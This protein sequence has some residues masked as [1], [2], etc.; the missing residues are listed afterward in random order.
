MLNM[1][2]SICNITCKTDRHTHTHSHSVREHIPRQYVHVHLRILYYMHHVWENTMWCQ[3]KKYAE[4]WTAVSGLVGSHQQ[5]IP[6][7]LSLASRVYKGCHERSTCG[8]E[9]MRFITTRHC[10]VHLRTYI[11]HASCL[12]NAHTSCIQRKR[13]N[14]FSLS[15][16][17]NTL[18]EGY[19]C[20][21]ALHLV[22][23][24]RG[25]WPWYYGVCLSVIST[26]HFGEP[27]RE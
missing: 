21:L 9:L 5:S 10:Y 26:T 23:W 20:A 27:A 3:E 16:E 6:Q 22:F 25:Q 14:F 11:L 1:V 12:R 18:Q 13:E 24:K 17:S 7:L 4:L 8:F 19:S 15:R 2:F